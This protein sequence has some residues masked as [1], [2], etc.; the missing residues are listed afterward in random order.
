MNKLLK[1]LDKQGYPSNLIYNIMMNIQNVTEEYHMLQ[2]I[3]K[4]ECGEGCKDTEDNF[5]INMCINFY[6]NIIYLRKYLSELMDNFDLDDDNHKKAI[7][8][9]RV[10]SLKCKKKLSIYNQNKKYNKKNITS[11]IKK[12]IFLK[13]S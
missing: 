4:Q 12:K 3:I 13:T 11:K 2:D 1:K 10:K 9:N 7:I 5:S 8:Y 6:K